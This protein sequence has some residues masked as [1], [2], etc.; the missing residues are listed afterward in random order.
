MEQCFRRA[1]LKP[2]HIQAPLL[3]GLGQGRGS[4]E[5]GRTMALTD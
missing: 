4:T 5:A 2:T 1:Q 3:L